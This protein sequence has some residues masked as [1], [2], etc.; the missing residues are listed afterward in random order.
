MLDPPPETPNGSLARAEPIGEV[1]RRLLRRHELDRCSDRER[2]WRAWEEVVG[3]D[4][5]HTELVG[6]QRN[7][8][9]FRVDSSPLL[10]E[11]SSFRKQELLEGLRARVKS[12]FVRD[13]R[14]RL[15]KRRTPAP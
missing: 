6:L 14:F 13:L 2:V 15:E 11:L 9:T 1:V 4:A 8:A 5:A 10:A 12:Y 7:V 3:R